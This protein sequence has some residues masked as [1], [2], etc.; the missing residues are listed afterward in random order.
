M[1]P[2]RISIYTHL[3][4]LQ[5]FTARLAEDLTPDE[6]IR[7]TRVIDVYTRLYVE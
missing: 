4:A 2:P 3:S 6:R 1:R 5:K 7:L